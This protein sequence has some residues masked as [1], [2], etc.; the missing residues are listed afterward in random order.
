MEMRTGWPAPW[1]NPEGVR[2]PANLGMSAS[3][4]WSEK[5]IN[6]WYKLG[7]W[8]VV[9]FCDTKSNCPV[10]NYTQQSDSDND[11]ST[12]NS[13]KVAPS[14]PSAVDT[15]HSRGL[16]GLATRDEMLGLTVLCVGLSK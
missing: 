10:E 3:M 1:K 14:N 12:R 9:K 13:A 2:S 5:N 7:R 16:S 4:F 8:H 11:T 6:C 15:A